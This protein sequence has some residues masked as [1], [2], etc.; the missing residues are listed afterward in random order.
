MNNTLP[1]SIYSN[2]WLINHVLSVKILY[3]F[4]AGA[5]SRS[6][7]MFFCFHYTRLGSVHF[8]WPTWCMQLVYYVCCYC[9]AVVKRVFECFQKM[10]NLISD[11]LERRLCD[12]VLEVAWSTMW[13]V[14]DETPQNCQRFLEN[15]GMKHFLACLKVI[16]ESKWI[17]NMEYK[18]ISVKS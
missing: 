17:I 10:L 3:F 5:G 15:R 7:D 13:N 11:R 9:I 4:F 12:D 18:I 1:I 16:F 2:E 8:G 6:W 14:T